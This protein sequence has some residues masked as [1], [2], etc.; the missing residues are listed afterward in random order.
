VGTWNNVRCIA[1]SDENVNK[2]VFEKDDAVAEAVLYK[3]PTYEDRTVVCCSTQSG[4]PIGCRFCGAGDSFVRSLTAEEIVSQTE[5]LFSDKGI[6][7]TKVERMQIMFMSMGEPMLN[8]KGLNP[9]MRELNDLYPVASLLVSTSAPK[10]DYQ[11]FIDLS[12]EI[13]KV[14]LQFSVHESTNEA[15]NY[16][17]PFKNKLTLEEIAKQ[18]TEW[19]M[20]VGR[21]PFFNYCAHEKNSSA[22]DADRVMKL[23]DPSIWQATIS[24]ICERE[25]SIAAANVRQREL[26]SNFQSLL[27]ERGFSTRMFDPA[28]Q[29]DIGGGCGQLWFVQNWM[30]NNPNLARPSTGRSLPVIHTPR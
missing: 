9:A 8:L 5:H 14:G 7:A 6:D 25:E 30:K 23:F 28:G 20:A 3:Y 16:L 10:V 21:Q 2:Y 19:C 26:A 27:L 12:K 17:V 29:D 1:S 13:D 15:R 22:E 4:C 18:G 11:P 24:V